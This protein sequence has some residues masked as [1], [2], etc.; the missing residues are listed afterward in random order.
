MEIDINIL[1]RAFINNVWLKDKVNFSFSYGNGDIAKII[2][3]DYTAENDYISFTYLILNENEVPIDIRVGNIPMILYNAE[4][5]DNRIDD[6]LY[7]N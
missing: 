7:E 4:L 3:E 6:I 5:R 1:K 2:I